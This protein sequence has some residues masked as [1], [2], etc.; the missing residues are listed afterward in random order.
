[1]KKAKILIVEDNSV[2]AED[3]RIRLVRMGYRHVATAKNYEKAIQ[4]AESQR[5]DL[6]LMDIKLGDGKN[7]IDMAD[8]FR[9]KYQIPVVYLTAFADDDTIARAKETEPY[10]YIVKPFDDK[11]LHSAVEIALHK[12]KADRQLRESRQWFETTLNSIGDGVIATNA[13][14][15]V[16]FMNPVTE[17]L[18]GWSHKA[19]MGKPVKEVF[20]LINEETRCAVENPVER[21]LR[22]KEVAGLANHTLLITRDGRQIPIADSAAPILGDKGDVIGAVLVFRDQTRERTAQRALEESEA[23]AIPAEHIT[24]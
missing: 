15:R 12:Q 17:N 1:M 18:T 21:V 7:G 5:P 10:G 14:G 4:A 22:E 6:A 13:E 8:L 23:T 20:H 11:E 24:H 2:V 9:R 16:T 19:A 3:I